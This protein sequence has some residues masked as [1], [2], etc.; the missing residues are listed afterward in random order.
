MPESKSSVRRLRAEGR[1]RQAWQLR[2]GGAEFPDIAQQLGYA[3]RSGAYLAFQAYVRK[4]HREDAEVNKALNLGRLNRL[5]L[6]IWA[7]ATGGDE[8]AVDRALAIIKEMNRMMG[9]YEPLKVDMT[10][11]RAEA[12]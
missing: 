3:N 8:S 7:V 2:M 4:I 1:Q 11:I 10:L 12:E 9:V 6:A 5:L